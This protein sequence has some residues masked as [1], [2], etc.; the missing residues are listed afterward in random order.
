MANNIESISEKMR[1]QRF[2]RWLSPVDVKFSSSEAERGYKKRVNRFIKTIRL[3]KPDRVPVILPAGSY[4]LYYAGITLKEAM[5]DNDKLCQAYRKFFREFVADTFTSPAMV[6]SGKASEMIDS[7]SSKWPGH[8]LPDNAS[9][10]QFVEGEYM[11]AEEYDRF[12][13]DPSDFIFRVYLPRIYGTLQPVAKLPPFRT[14]I[15]GMG[16]TGLLSMLTTA[17]FKDLSRNL[18]KAAR[19]QE[20]VRKEGVEFSDVMNYLGFPSQYSGGLG[21]GGIGSAPFDT[22]SDNLRGMRGAMLDMY[23]CPDKLLAACDRILQWRLAQA[24]PA[25]PDAMGNRPRAG[26]PLHRGSDGFM[27]KSQFEKFYWPTLKRAI[28]ANVELG[29]VSAP[30]WEGIWDDKLEYLLE[31]PKGKVVFHCELTDIY[32]AKKV[33][34]DH[35]CIQGGIPPTIL[36]TGSPQDIEDLCKKLIKTVGKNGGFILGP[37]S[38]IDYARP[39]NIKAMV[40]S[41]K[42]YGWY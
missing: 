37:G 1:A 36:Q 40:D 2:E 19:E 27:S 34:G 6:P 9:M 3:E 5:Y 35:L 25:R 26:M 24:V 14:M 12:L 21:G 13:D 16:F 22:I 33:L 41:A 31:L 11:K 39:E 32:K 4:P 20:R 17:E 23:R 8:G 18:A 30:F 42:K 29:Y 15:G 7:L 10:Q 28:V 38:A